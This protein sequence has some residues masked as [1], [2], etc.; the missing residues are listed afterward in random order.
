MTQNMGSLAKKKDKVKDKGIS[1]Q[2]DGER[3]KIKLK[4]IEFV[5]RAIRASRIAVL[6]LT[7]K[8][9]MVK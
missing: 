5:K 8:Y 4:L 1:G 7:S 6:I 3:G 2:K 9:E